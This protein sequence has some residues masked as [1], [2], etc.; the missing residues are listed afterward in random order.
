MKSVF[1]KDID[2]NPNKDTIPKWVASFGKLK[3]EMMA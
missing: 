1:K 3:K 2:T